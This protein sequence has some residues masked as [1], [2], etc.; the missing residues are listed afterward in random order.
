MVVESALIQRGDHTHSQ[1]EIYTE[2]ENLREI[3]GE[4]YKL[5]AKRERT[6]KKRWRVQRWWW[7]MRRVVSWSGGSGWLWCGGDQ[8]VILEGKR[9]YG[10]WR[11]LLALKQRR[12]E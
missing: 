5:R 7:V 9:R 12:R 4:K 1:T 11:R 8:V 10:A 2:I 3:E 6:K